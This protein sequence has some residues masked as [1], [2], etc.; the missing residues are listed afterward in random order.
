MFKDYND[1]YF[2]H[3]KCKK[4]QQDLKEF[5]FETY[6]I[7][8]GFTKKDSYYLFKK[9]GKKDLVLFTTNLGKKCLT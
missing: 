1:I 4:W 2:E 7:P 8:V 6:Y 5:I 3:K 9:G